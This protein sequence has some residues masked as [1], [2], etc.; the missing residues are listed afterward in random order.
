MPSYSGK[1]YRKTKKH[2]QTLVDYV[3]DTLIDHLRGVTIGEI[4]RVAGTI[5]LI[6]TSSGS[7]HELSFKR[8][9]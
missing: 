5:R 8:I 7:V 1:Y 3:G 4:D 6:S 9:Q 2:D